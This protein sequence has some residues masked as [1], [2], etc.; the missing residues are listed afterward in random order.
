MSINSFLGLQVRQGRWDKTKGIYKFGFHPSVGS[1]EVTISDNGSDYD[2]LTE[3]SVI[4]VS[5]SNTNDTSDG[6][7]ART[8]RLSGLD[9]DYNEVEETVTL[10]GQTA[11]NTTNSY[12][13]IFRAKVLTAGTGEKNAGDIHMGTGAVSSGV[14][15]T[16]IA[17]IS[18]NENQTL[19]AVWTVPAGFTGYLYQVDF[20]S[21]VQ[22]SVYLTA[23]VKVREF[24]SVYQT[25]EKGTF[26]NNA[27][28]FDLELPTVI[29]EKS[30]IK[31]TCQASANTHAVSGSFIMLYI[32]N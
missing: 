10:N 27:L 5:S 12:L 8:V 24:G 30:D 3:A 7:G 20:S 17:K 16:S 32:K 14:P 11:V 4:K 28:R 2:A 23:R 15:A 22:G 1:S 6:T 19:M 31:L 26:T 25:K 9:G 21:N 18:S 29:T 13:R